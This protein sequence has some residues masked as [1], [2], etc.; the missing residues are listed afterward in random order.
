MDR[1]CEKGRAWAEVQLCTGGG[2][3]E[4]ATL[5]LVVYVWN[6]SR[7]SFRSKCMHAWHLIYRL[8][9]GRPVLLYPGTVSLWNKGRSCEERRHQEN[10]N[11]EGSVDYKY[12]WLSHNTEV[13][14]DRLVY[15]IMYIYTHNSLFSGATIGPH[16]SMLV[17]HT[18]YWWHCHVH[19]LCKSMSHTEYQ[20]C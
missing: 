2:G 8:F 11:S 5:L 10:A 15:M 20:Y 7:H 16:A 14:V 9:Q 17:K 19:S 3:G 6:K 18:I 12:V 4:M 13:R 1:Q